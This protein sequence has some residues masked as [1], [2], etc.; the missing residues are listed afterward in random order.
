MPGLVGDTEARL[1]DLEAGFASF[2]RR[3]DIAALRIAKDT[4]DLALIT[5]L[6]RV[7]GTC[8]ATLQLTISA[9]GAPLSSVLVT[10]TQ[11]GTSFSAFTNGAG[12]ATVGVNAAGTWTYSAVLAGYTTATGSQSA[13]CGSTVSGTD[14][15]PPTTPTAISFAIQGRCDFSTSGIS[16]V[17]GV[18]ITLTQ[19]ATTVTGTTGAGGTVTINVVNSGAWAWSA[20]KTR[21]ATQTGTTTAVCGSTVGAIVVNLLPDTGY[22]CSTV[23]PEPIATTLFLTDSNGI[24][25]LTFSAPDFAWIGCYLHTFG[26]VAGAVGLAVQ[27]NG[28]QLLQNFPGHSGSST[29][30]PGKCTANKAVK[31][32]GSDT[33]DIFAGSLSFPTASLTCA[34]LAISWTVTGSLVNGTPTAT[35]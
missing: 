11:G 18:L 27:T 25:T 34:P 22:T 32:T 20:T 16:G 19:G 2:R 13:V 3:L 31:D 4:Q 8:T 29:I 7:P 21:W 15:M 24:H 1:R 5:Q 9:C 35:E 26:G 6:P 33:D 23:C 28:L 17:S 10:W 14:T 30:G 12:L